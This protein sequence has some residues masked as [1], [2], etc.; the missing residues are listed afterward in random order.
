MEQLLFS[1]ETTM[2]KL[3]VVT[4]SNSSSS[5]STPANSN[6]L[7]ASGSFDSPS[8]VSLRGKNLKDIELDRRMEQIRKTFRIPQEEN[9]L[10][11]GK[12]LSSFLFLIL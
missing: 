5:T 11:F 10:V 9:I 4:N 2:E 8:R 7:T 3:F 12:K 1:A 6:T